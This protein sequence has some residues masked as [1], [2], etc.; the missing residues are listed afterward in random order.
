MGPDGGR[1]GHREG[2]ALTAR[3][4]ALTAE[5]VTATAKARLQEKRLALVVQQKALAAAA[6]E[7]G[8]EAPAQ[9]E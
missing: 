7:M 5:G 9:G 8:A 6:A 3:K 2:H 4:A 1:K